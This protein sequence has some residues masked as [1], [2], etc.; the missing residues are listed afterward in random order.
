MKKE[1]NR[2]EFLQLVAAGIALC[3]AGIG[4]QRLILSEKKGPWLT[5]P[6]LENRLEQMEAKKNNLPDKCAVII[7]GDNSKLHIRNV[8]LAYNVLKQN[9]FM[10]QNIFVLSYQKNTKD[11]QIPTYAPTFGNL[12]MLFRLLSD[13]IDDKDFLFIYGTGHGTKKGD[14]SEID[15]RKI[16]PNCKRPH[17]TSAISEIEFEYLIKDIHPNY[18]VLVFDQCHAGGFGTKLQTRENLVLVFR[19]TQHELGTCKHFAKAFFDAFGDASSDAD[20][21]DRIS[22]GE[23]FSKTLQTVNQV[24]PSYQTYQYTPSIKGSLDANTIYLDGSADKDNEAVK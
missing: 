20:N 7:N 5:F 19:A 15:I 2:R 17:L 8:S 9:D 18:G 21:N 22:I 14:V 13:T 23:A 3:L 12:Q 1:I 24:D 6:R 11:E 16:C 10:D 4:C